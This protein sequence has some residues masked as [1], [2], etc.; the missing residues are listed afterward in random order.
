MHLKRTKLLLI[1]PLE[2][3]TSLKVG[4]VSLAQKVSTPIIEWI[5]DV[6]PKSHI[7]E[8]KIRF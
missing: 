1:K 6:L 5:T 3:K 7:E 2:L 4:V 8:M